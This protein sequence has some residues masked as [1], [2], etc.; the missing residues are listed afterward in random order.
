MSKIYLAFYGE[1]YYPDGANDI[2][3]LFYT[4]EL[5]KDV[6]EKKHKEVRPDD[7]EHEFGYGHIYNIETGGITNIF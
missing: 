5:A 3:E 7:L 4:F 1:V 6:I 2:I